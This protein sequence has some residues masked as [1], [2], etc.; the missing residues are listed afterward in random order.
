MS[1]SYGSQSMVAPLKRVLVK[2][3]DEAFGRADPARWHYTSQPDLALARGEHDALTA[4][5]REA[6]TDVVFHDQPMPGHADAIYVFDPALV[7]DQG[8]VLLRMGKDLRRGEEA[9][10]GRVLEDLSIPIL[11]ALHGEA[12]AEGGDLLWV[13]ENTL[14]VGLGFRTNVA[15]FRQLC[16]ALDPLGVDVLPF[17]LPYYQGPEACLHL[18]SLISLVDEDLAVVYPPLMPVTFWQFLNDR[19]IAMIE[20]PENEFLTMGPNVLATAPRRCIMLAGNP[21]TQAKLEAAGCAVQTYVGDEISHKAEGGP[22]CLT[23]PLWRVY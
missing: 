9:M 14:A 19:G 23:R 7:T 3:P 22:T 11:Y 16:E 20:V 10:L 21:V 13:D 8:A 18:L 4:L 2:R 1:P 17:E 5:L 12:R 15:G 6:G